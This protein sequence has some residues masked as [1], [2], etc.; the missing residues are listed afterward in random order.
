M[1]I[2]NGYL[3]DCVDDARLARRGINPAN[4]HND[5]VKQKELDLR[6]GK[7]DV[8]A[9]DETKPGDLD[10]NRRAGPA[11]T[12]GGSLSIE[13]RPGGSGERQSA[14]LVDKLA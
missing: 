6:H 14:P 9:L 4:P 13:T 3:V 8:T 7:I 10:P 1:R 12:F 5:P 2:V 11:V